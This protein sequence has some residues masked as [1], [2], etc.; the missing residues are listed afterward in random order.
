MVGSEGLS[1]FTVFKVEWSGGILLQ[2]KFRAQKTLNSNLA[3]GQVKSA[4]EPS[5]PSGQSLSR[6]L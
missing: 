3:L 5:S 6:F 4:Y 1:V 2:E